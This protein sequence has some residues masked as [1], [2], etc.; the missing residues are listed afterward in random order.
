MAKFCFNCG[1]ELDDNAALC[2]NCDVI[3]EN[4]QNNSN[5]VNKTKMDK[6]KGLP[7]WAIVLIVIGCVILI[8]LIFIILIGVFA[9]NVVNSFDNYD[10]ETITQNGTIGDVLTTDEFNITLHD[11]LIYSSIGTDEN[12]LDIP[13]EGKEYLVFFF[14]VKNI[15]DDN[16]YISAF[17]FT[18]YV[19]GIEVEKTYL[20]N[21]IDGIE[22]LTANLPPNKKTKGFVAFEVDTIWQEFEIHYE[23]WFGS[24]ELVFAVVKEENSSIADA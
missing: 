9:Y 1:K 17:D 4:A 19:N 13:E 24:N 3:V 22:E 15:S 11:A 18:G 23:D 8:P 20:Y 2:L 21:D 7:T 12:R 16:E 5:N 14:E 6:K 10:E